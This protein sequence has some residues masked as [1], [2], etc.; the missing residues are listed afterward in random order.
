MQGLTDFIIDFILQGY[1]GLFIVCFIF[2]MIP[3]A[4]PSNM[5]L[6]GFAMVFL[7]G[8]NWIIVGIVVAIS[9]TL[10]KLIHYY[11]VRGSRLVMSEERLALLDRERDRVNKWGAFALFIAAASPVPDDP[12]IIYVGFTKYSVVKLTLSYF[13]GKVAVTLAGAFIGEILGPIFE[14]APIMM[15]SIALTLIITVILFR[16]KRDSSDTTTHEEVRDDFSY[17]DDESKSDIDAD[18]DEEMSGRNS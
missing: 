8:A 18:S 9:A 4:G 7:P 6:A 1:L 16:P 14:S 12:L 15:G 5:V 17:T 11:T 2:N 3:I 10:S 13:A